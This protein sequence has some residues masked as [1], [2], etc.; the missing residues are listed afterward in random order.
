MHCAVL[1]PRPLHRAEA[2]TRRLHAP[3]HGDGNAER[4]VSR[5]AG[6]E[7]GVEAANTWLAAG[8]R[9][10]SR[11]E[12]DDDDDDD[13]DNDIANIAGGEERSGA[14]GEGTLEMRRDVEKRVAYF[15]GM[16]RECDEEVGARFFFVCPYR[17]NTR[18]DDGCARLLPSR[19]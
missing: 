7:K 17:I 4:G 19:A 13:D 8:G 10:T 6:A 15:Q 11:P 5:S 9:G 2:K 3:T 12:K 16:V 18:P 14:G 1:V